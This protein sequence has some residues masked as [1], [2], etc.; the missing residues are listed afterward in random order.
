MIKIETRAEEKRELDISVIC[1]IEM[2]GKRY[3]LISE[4]ASIITT[5]EERYP[6]IIGGALQ[7]MID[8]EKG[9]V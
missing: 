1:K 4:L 5:I 7:L 6:G 2:E 9:R 3:M 8:K